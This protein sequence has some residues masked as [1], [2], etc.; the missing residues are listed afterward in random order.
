MNAIH[1]AQQDSL[2]DSLGDHESA[3]RCSVANAQVLIGTSG[4]SFDDWKGTYYPSSLPNKDMLDYYARDFSIVEINA[5][6]YRLLPSKTYE[7]MLDRV[8][9]D[10]RF[11]VK[12]YEGLTHRRELDDSIVRQFEQSVRPLTDAHRLEAVLLQFP[13]SFRHTPENTD[14]LIQ[15]VYHFPTLRL[16]AEFRN[17]TW[18]IPQM[19]RLLH[20]S[21]VAFCCV[22]EPRLEGLM[23][24]FSLATRKDLGYVRLHGRNAKHWWKGGALR[25]DYDYSDQE[26]AEWADKIQ[27]LVKKTGRVLTFFNNCHLG[28][29]VKNAK[30]LRELLNERG[31]KVT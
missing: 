27:S 15:L 20:D 14:R 19:E 18:A 22:D 12:A 4:Y 5:S 10:F 11:V 16:A 24:N 8:P 26:L 31:L 3:T 9:K 29:A 25:Y 23:P 13:W 30:S 1:D 6:Y 7:S 17:N 21:R 2:F 28:Q